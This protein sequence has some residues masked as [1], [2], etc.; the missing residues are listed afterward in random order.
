MSS[1][2]LVALCTGLGAMLLLSITFMAVQQDEHRRSGLIPGHDPRAETASLLDATLR[3]VPV[4]QVRAGSLAFEDGSGLLLAEPDARLLDQLSHL[5]TARE[6]FLERVYEMSAGWR[7]VF[8]GGS[9]QAFV[10]VRSWHLV[11]PATT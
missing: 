8:R 3:A 4:R 10:D 9:M 11:A 2:Y 7:L 6:V 1:V 5:A